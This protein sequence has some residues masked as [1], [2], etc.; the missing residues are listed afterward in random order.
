MQNL[1]FQSIELMFRFEALN[2]KQRMLQLRQVTQVFGALFPD[3]GLVT[4]DVASLALRHTGEECAA[5]YP[6]LPHP[7]LPCPEA[8]GAAEPTGG[9]IQDREGNGHQEPAG[10]C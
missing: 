2:T 5:E 1:I 3:R 10:E 9:A 4:T 8:G 6:S 7:R